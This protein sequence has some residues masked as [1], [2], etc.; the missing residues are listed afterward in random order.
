MAPR[1]CRHGLVSL[2]GAMYRE[3]ACAL[4]LLPYP[5]ATANAERTTGLLMK[6]GNCRHL[7]AV[8][9]AVGWGDPGEGMS[10]LNRLGT[11]VPRLRSR[12]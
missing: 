6:P 1:K 2:C 7:L 5:E 4:I 11:P 3:V 10:G 8:G 9:A 12:R